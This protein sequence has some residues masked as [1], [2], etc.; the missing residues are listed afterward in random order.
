MKTTN[1][2]PKRDN[3]TII[4]GNTSA[5]A[6]EYNSGSDTVS[7]IDSY[8]YLTIMAD[9]ITSVLNCP[10]TKASIGDNR[11]Y[12]YHP[13]GSV[14]TNII[15]PTLADRTV[16]FK[17]KG[18]PNKPVVSTHRAGTM[19]ISKPAE[20]GIMFSWRHDKFDSECYGS[21]TELTLRQELETMLE[22][23]DSAMI[24]NLVKYLQQEQA[25]GSNIVVTYPAIT[26]DS[27]RLRDIADA[28]DEQVAEIRA[29]MVS[30]GTRSEDWCIGLSVKAYAAME[31]IAK[32]S[33]AHSV[34]AY[35]GCPVA[36]FNADQA[37]AIEGYLVPR[38]HVVASFAEQ[39]DGVVF[40]AIVTRDGNKQASTL[41]LMAS[42]HL[43]CAGFTSLEVPQEDGS[44][45]TKDI[46]MPL[47][48]KFSVSVSAA[49]PV[50]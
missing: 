16:T 24:S 41:E 1:N 8:Q 22:A 27:S 47:I 37:D 49:N 33:D 9:R 28:I 4:D 38:R 31:F 15:V 21:V 19:V 50:S 26:A 13:H 6:V 29:K 18:Q 3:V 42:C 11:F 44:L 7:S 12:S 20:S 45:A 43:V 48:G 14:P 23:M 25:E 32:R 10:E 30:L 35:L 40:N 36:I 5:C 34:E 17:L 2:Q 46:A 39:S